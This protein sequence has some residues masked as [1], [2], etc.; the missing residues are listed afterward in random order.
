MSN[1]AAKNAILKKIRVALE[2]PT[3]LPFP[4][5]E[6]NETVFQPQQQDLVV[7]FAEQFTSLQGKFIFCADDKELNEQF[8]N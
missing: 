2:H 8:E 1:S 5:A 6:N 7:E 3:P 4:K